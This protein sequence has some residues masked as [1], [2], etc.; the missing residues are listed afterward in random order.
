ML[1][2]SIVGSG[3][4]TMGST[5]KALVPADMHRATGGEAHSSSG[6]KA[7]LRGGCIQQP[8]LGRQRLLGCGPPARHHPRHRQGALRRNVR[9]CMHPGRPLHNHFSGCHDRKRCSFHVHITFQAGSRVCAVA[10]DAAGAAYTSTISAASASNLA[11][12]APPCSRVV[13]FGSNGVACADCEQRG[14]AG[15][16][17]RLGRSADVCAGCLQRR[18]SC[19]TSALPPQAGG[20]LHSL[21]CPF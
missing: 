17:G 10:A 3:Q 12:H 8:E 7:Q 2:A 13:W 6:G 20:P 1:G 11:N 4:G 19:S 15:G 21:L 5:Q 18:R 14:N 9:A 16:Q